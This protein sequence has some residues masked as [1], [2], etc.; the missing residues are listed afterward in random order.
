MDSNRLQCNVG[1]NHMSK[2]VRLA[3][4]QKEDS[5]YNSKIMDLVE[6]W[7]LTHAT[8]VLLVTICVLMVLFVTLIFVMT[9]VSAT[10]SGVQYNQFNNII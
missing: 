2:P 5:F 7:V 6:A 1:V 9:G 10:E 4:S 8:L 3:K